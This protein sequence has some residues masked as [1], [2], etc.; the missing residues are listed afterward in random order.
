MNEELQNF[1]DTQNFK[2]PKEI[3]EEKPDKSLKNLINKSLEEYPRN[4]NK[5]NFSGA[6][7]QNQIKKIDTQ[8][9]KEN[10]G[11]YEKGNNLINNEINNNQ[12]KTVYTRSNDVKFGQHDNYSFFEVYSRELIFQ[13]FNYHETFFFYYEIKKEDLMENPEIKINNS[14]KNEQSATESDKLNSDPSYNKSS[15]SGNDKDS[16]SNE[17]NLN[18]K[19]E[20]KKNKLKKPIYKGDV[21]CLIPNLKPNELIG[22]LNNKEFSPFIF[23]GNINFEKNSDLLVEIKESIS[24]SDEKHIIQL[25]KYFDIFDLSK[26]NKQINDKFG[27]TKENQK[28]IL[29]VFNNNY[30]GFLLRMLAYKSHRKKFV[31]TNESFR[32]KVL[33]NI[34]TKKFIEGNENNILKIEH[35]DLIKEIISSNRPYI[36]LFIQDIIMLYYSLQKKIKE[37]EKRKE[38]E[39]KEQNEKEKKLKLEKEKQ[40]QIELEK[41][42]KEKLME[43]K[44][45]EQNKENQ[46]I[47]KIDML[48]ES[49]KK[50]NR[51]LSITTFLILLILLLILIIL[52]IL[53]KK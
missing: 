17:I 13:L 51:T 12:K 31:E 48:I 9:S 19:K 3:K 11:I 16:S 44:L 36:F 45:D 26:D 43:K 1:C 47:L 21:D 50:L 29:Y 2:I 24:T 7:S 25:K 5:I 46:L 33:S 30:Y 8:E 35:Q 32:T 42:N 4:K 34:D 39:I 40:D 27:F 6:E 37:E 53:L 49:Q 41:Q 23:Y 18:Q 38:I 14:K 52:I 20:K 10:K 15:Y 22:F 28:I